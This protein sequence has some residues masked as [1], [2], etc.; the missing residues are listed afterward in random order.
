MKERFADMRNLF[1][2]KKALQ[3]VCNGEVCPLSEIPDEAFSSGMLGQGYAIRPENGR[4]LCPANGRVASIAEAKHA[5]TILTSDGLDLLVH[6]GV[7]TVTLGGEGFTPKVAEG[8]TVQ[9]GAPLAE[10]DLSLLEQRGIPTIT[11][12]LLTNADHLT[13]IECRMGRARGGQDTVFTFRIG[14]KG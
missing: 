13:N 5:Y 9:A 7:D 11:A 3:A 1:Q 12:V 4:F 2:R 8:D 14:G 10:V 6:I